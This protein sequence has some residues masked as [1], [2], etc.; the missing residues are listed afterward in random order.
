MKMGNDGSSL[1][2][3]IGDILLETNNGNCLILKKVKHIFDVRL[4]LLSTGKLDDEGYTYKFAD[5]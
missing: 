5:G 1:I 2:I 4:N 3:D